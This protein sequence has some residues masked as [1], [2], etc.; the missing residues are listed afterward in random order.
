MIVEMR[1]DKLNDLLAA[2]EAE[3]KRADEAEGEREELRYLSGV[4]GIE[5]DMARADRERWKARAEALEA[6]LIE[7][8]CCV[9]CKKRLIGC[10]GQIRPCEQFVF[11]STAFP[12][13]M[14][15]T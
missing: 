14:K 6:A 11:D 12:R 8:Q 7:G 10:C 2:L 3:T 13:N 5:C 4:N 15:L 9:A 1:N